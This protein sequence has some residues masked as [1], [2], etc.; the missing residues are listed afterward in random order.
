LEFNKTKLKK[1]YNLWYEDWL[2]KLK[3]IV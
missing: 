3:D 2:E 1:L